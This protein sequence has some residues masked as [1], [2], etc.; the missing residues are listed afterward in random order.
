MDS[1]DFFFNKNNSPR[2]PGD[3]AILQA[4]LLLVT[5]QA[6]QRIGSR[7]FLGKW[8]YPERG[9]LY[10]RENPIKMEDDWGTPMTTETSMS[11]H[12]LMNMQTYD[13]NILLCTGS[14]LQK[15]NLLN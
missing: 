14:G 3:D 2:C 5:V 4:P 13:C 1:E 6:K 10:V 9:M 7:A 11:A 12:I 15:K 8:G